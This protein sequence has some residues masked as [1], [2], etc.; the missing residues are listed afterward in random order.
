MTTFTS[1]WKADG[2][3]HNKYFNRKNKYSQTFAYDDI[4]N[5]TVKTSANNMYSVNTDGNDVISEQADAKLNY[6]F[7]YSYSV[8]KPHQLTSIRRYYL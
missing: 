1:L 3:Y 5:M 4:G 8:S 6:N 7:S 2:T